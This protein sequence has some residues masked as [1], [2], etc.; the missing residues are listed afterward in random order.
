MR[1]RGAGGKG[2]RGE[3]EGFEGLVEGKGGR[4]GVGGVGLGKV[5]HATCWIVPRARRK[6]QARRSKGLWTV[7]VQIKAEQWVNRLASLM[8]LLYGRP[9]SVCLNK[10]WHPSSAAPS[11]RVG[12]GFGLSLCQDWLQQLRLKPVD[13]RSVTQGND[14]HVEG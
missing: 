9:G 6:E 11:V 12:L 8:F 10:P 13:L 3:G 14:I 4:L 2:G 1:G 7:G 5:Q